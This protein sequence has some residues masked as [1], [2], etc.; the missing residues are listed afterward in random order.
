MVVS[1]LTNVLLILVL[2]VQPAF[3]V[4][5]YTTRET[6]SSKQKEPKILSNDIYL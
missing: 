4:Q 3:G 5:K 2:M 1:Q 6:D